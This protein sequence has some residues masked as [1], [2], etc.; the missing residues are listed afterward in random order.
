MNLLEYEQN[1]YHNPA[2]RNKDRFL[3]KIQTSE[4]C[5]NLQIT[6]EF[7]LTN[8]KCKIFINNAE[9]VVILF[10]FLTPSMTQF[11]HSFPKYDKSIFVFY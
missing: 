8:N 7:G 6:P 10:P 3:T 1:Q 11:F 9:S 5:N 2:L 4:N